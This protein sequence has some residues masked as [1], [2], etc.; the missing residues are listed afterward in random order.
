MNREEIK[1]RFPNASNSFIEANCSGK[2][3][4][5]ECYKQIA[6]DSEALPNRQNPKRI[7]VRITSVRKRL[8]DEDRICE[9]FLVDC[10]RYAGIIPNDSPDVTHIITTQRKVSEGEQ[11]HTLIEIEYPTAPVESA[12]RD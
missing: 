10:L 11:E 3:T 12:R 2:I 4:E 9:V 1:S 6:L 5:L 8:L 7:L